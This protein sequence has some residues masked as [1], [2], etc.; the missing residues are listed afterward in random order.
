MGISWAFLLSVIFT[1]GNLKEVQGCQ[2]L[3]NLGGMAMDDQTSPYCRLLRAPP[4]EAISWFERRAFVKTYKGFPHGNAQ[5]YEWQN[6]RSIADLSAFFLRGREERSAGGV[7][8]S[9][10]F[11]FERLRPEPVGD[12][13]CGQSG[14]PSLKVECKGW[15]EV[16][17]KTNDAF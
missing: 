11:S 2:L 14:P 7:D 6:P 3:G 16:L 1:R 17:W 8:G 4:A 13:V 5:L 9:T 10:H 15:Q 12:G